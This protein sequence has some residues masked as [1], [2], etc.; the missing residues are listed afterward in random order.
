MARESYSINGVGGGNP[1]PTNA[2]RVGRA[3][4]LNTKLDQRNRILDYYRSTGRPETAEKILRGTM[5][6][7]GVI[8]NMADRVSMRGLGYWTPQGMNSRV[9]F[10]DRTTAVTDAEWKNAMARLQRRRRS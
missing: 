9:S 8:G 6:V 7:G 1:N 4:T 10:R 3:A 5:G 2:V